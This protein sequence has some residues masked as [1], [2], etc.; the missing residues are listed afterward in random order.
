MKE[1]TV[2]GADLAF[3]IGPKIL[4]EFDNKNFHY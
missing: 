3:A 4:K 1:I 2:E